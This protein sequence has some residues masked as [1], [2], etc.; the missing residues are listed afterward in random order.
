MNSKKRH[1]A[2]I[3]TVLVVDDSLPGLLA[4]KAM[5]E[6]EGVS[7]DTAMDGSSALSMALKKQYDA[8][9][10][11]E[12]MPGLLGSALCAELRRVTGPSQHALMISLSG[13][14]DQKWRDEIKTA[15]FDLAL[16]KPVNKRE[17]MAAL[18]Q[19]SLAINGLQGSEQ[20]AGN[21]HA[22]PLF[23]VA[24]MSGQF[25]ATTVKRLFGLFVDELSVL[26]MRL[27]AAIDRTSA[28]EVLAV[29][30]IMKNS[31]SLY[32]ARRLFSLARQLHDSP[33]DTPERV[34]LHAQHILRVCQ[35]TREVIAKIL[36]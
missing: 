36:H 19:Q 13:E 25:D 30:H 27:T 10:L 9:L 21:H 6:T 14:S 1:E 34:L 26:S 28:I 23:D 20:A 15:G 11:D 4:V 7:C 17:L 32:G 18:S 35:Q 29:T 16:Q 31:A 2:M 5:L 33:P 8:V 22:E 12:Y 3:Q 24:E